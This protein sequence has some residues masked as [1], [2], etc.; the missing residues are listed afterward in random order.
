MKITSAANPHIKD[1]VKLRRSHHRKARD[2]FIIENARCIERAM[3]AGVRIVQ[4]FVCPDLL[5]DPQARRVA[6]RLEASGTACYEVPEPVFAKAAY[7]QRPEGLLVVAERP[8]HTL[9]DL[10]AADR[11]LY[12]LA[13]S[14]EKP[15]NLGA[16]LRSADAVG[17]A[18]LILCDRHT[19]VYNPNA[20]TASTGTVFT[21]PI[22]EAT[23]DE[24]LAWLAA[25][26]AA[27]LATV[28]EGGRPYTDVDL[29]APV[30]IALGTEHEGLSD[31]VQRAASE[32][33]TIP[34]AGTADSLNVAAAATV[35]L[36]E[37]A[38][39]RRERGRGGCA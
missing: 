39:Q 21:V 31:A 32:K 2:R 34:M 22:A 6:G 36:F 12:V 38:R 19:D 37:A 23:T 35:V 15:G 30:A 7:R 24:A 11:P 25:R 10:P 17:A 28:C 9:N 14:L 20:V 33:I 5:T 16:I 1:L 18:G 13:E 26:G 27:V 4:V 8:S 3:D 29:T